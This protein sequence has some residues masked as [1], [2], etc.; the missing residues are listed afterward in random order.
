MATP[1]EIY[2]AGLKRDISV[3]PLATPL[4]AGREPW[5]DY[6]LMADAHGNFGHQAAV[7]ASVAGCD[8][9]YTGCIVDCQSDSSVSGVTG[10]Q[11]I[12]RIS[13]ILLT[14]LAVQFIIDGIGQSGL[15][16]H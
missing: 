6:I 4:I 16:A 13:G 10:I 12:M 1:E 7:F 15:L 2:E 14:S 3:F 5:G 9:V 11:V 8:V